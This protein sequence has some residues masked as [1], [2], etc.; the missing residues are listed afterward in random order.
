M[1]LF[2]SA[3]HVHLFGHKE[4]SKD[5]DV[6][7]VK[8]QKGFKVYFPTMAPNK[9]LINYE[10]KP[11]DKVK[12]GQKIG[13]R[14]DFEVPIYSSVSGVVKENENVLHASIGA[15]IPHIVIESD[16]EMTTVESFKKVALKDKKEKIFAAI[17]EAGI[18]GMGG[19]GFPLYIKYTTDAEID[20]LLVN[21]VECE[22]FLTTD[23][24]ST[25]ADA[26]ALVLGIQYLMKVKDIEKA[27][28]CIKV[29][30]E[31]ARDAVKEAIKEFDNIHVVEVP[32]AYPMG[33][34]RTLIKKV[35]KRTYVKLPAEAHVIVNNVQ[36][37][38][39]IGKSLSTGNAILT[40]LV[41]VSG[42]AIA[43][44]C[45]VEVPLGTPANILIE[46]CG[47]YSY[48]G[49]ISVLP[50]GPMCSKAVS[51][52]NFP[53]HLPNGAITIL[54]Y[55][56]IPAESCLR[57]G[58]CVEHCPANLRPIFLKDVFESKNVDRMI[59]LHA[60]DCIECGSCSYICPSH[61]DVS[62]YVKKC[63]ALVRMRQAKK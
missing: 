4:L 13:T 37:V 43:Y 10:I 44:P 46:K 17:K 19:A 15:A 27:I 8:P 57:C 1:G 49:E 29:H 21:A 36:S 48:D 28:V 22:P 30:K 61:I 40:R 34:E 18:V 50:G 11:G 12:A 23:Y 7:V 60:M 41:T 47:G 20:T 31:A 55:V 39:S 32:D 56:K 59:E 16:G 45:N 42:D 25:K 33:W 63:K 14:T 6:I 9:S 5:Q 58:R 2:T 52:D 26:E 3:G 24:K 51:A 53:I 54:K 38:I 62:D 35:L